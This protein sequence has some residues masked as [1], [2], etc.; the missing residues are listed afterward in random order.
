MY[1]IRSYYELSDDSI[2]IQPSLSVAYKGFGAN[3][4]AN[5]D[6]DLV[7]YGSNKWNETDFTLS[8][9]GAYEK[10]G[11]GVGWI[12]YAL[13]SVSDTQ[14]F[15]ATASYDTILA[16]SLTI[17]YDTDAFAGDWYANFSIGHS[18]A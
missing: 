12:Y 2:V 17:Y 3:L 15:Y 5:L 8:Y 16:P 1:A 14:E 18:F 4:W 10:F 7:G 13:D 11:Y 9:D 6:T